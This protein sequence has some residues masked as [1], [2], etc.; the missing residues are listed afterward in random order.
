MLNFDGFTFIGHCQ[1]FFLFHNFLEHFIKRP[2][3]GKYERIL[4]FPSRI[5]VARIHI[6]EYDVF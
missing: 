3:L 5:L 1:P 2:P 4:V 6:F